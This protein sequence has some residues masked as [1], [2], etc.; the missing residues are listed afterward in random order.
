[1][2]SSTMFVRS[3]LL[4]APCL[5][6][7]LAAAT[8]LAQGSTAPVVAKP[9]KAPVSKAPLPVRNMT[10]ELR[11]VG[12]VPAATGTQQWGTSA[13]Q[14]E[15][16][17]KV[18]VANGEQARF[19]FSTA[20]AWSWT[21][22]AVRGNGAGSVDGVSQ[23]LQWSQ[24][25]RALECMVAWGGGAKPARLE[26]SVQAA[27]GGNGALD[28]VQPQPVT[29]KVQTVVLVPLGEWFTL[30]RSGPR[31]QVQ[32]QGSYSSRSAQASE[33]RLLQVRVLAPD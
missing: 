29:H 21:Q 5:A 8:A 30:A 6:L 32:T 2:S 25:V 17:Q 15:E 13:A 31:P 4:F 10:L 7:V 20:Q 22:S 9:Q 27:N 12:E 33:A 3:S 28:G 16:W 24:D 1:M 14:E 11:V 19:E 26:V 23:S 18:T